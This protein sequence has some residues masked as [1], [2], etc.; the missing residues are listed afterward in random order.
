MVG[1][2][3]MICTTRSEPFQLV[4]FRNAAPAGLGALLK[5]IAP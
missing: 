3:R 1:V 2:S 5:A 4:G